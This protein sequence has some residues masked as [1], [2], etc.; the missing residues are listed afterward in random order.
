M[1]TSRVRSGVRDVW[2]LSGSYFFQPQAMPPRFRF[3]VRGQNIFAP[4]IKSL[5]RELH[6]VSKALGS[7]AYFFMTIVYDHISSTGCI[8]LFTILHF[9]KISKNRN[10]KQFCYKLINLKKSY[11]ISDY[12]QWKRIL[13]SRYWVSP[14]F[15][16]TCSFSRN[17]HSLSQRILADPCA[18]RI[19]S[20]RGLQSEKSLSI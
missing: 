9:E 6:F 17:L 2:A 7:C 16:M 8:K 19:G 4:G 13:K 14:I 11:A 15:Q 3:W 1:R 12:S 18:G 20:F 10:S 5:R